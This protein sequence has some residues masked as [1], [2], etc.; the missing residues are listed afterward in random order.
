MYGYCRTSPHW[1]RAGGCGSSFGC[2]H[3]YSSEEFPEKDGV[4]LFSLRTVLVHTEEGIR[5]DLFA[6]SRTD[7][8]C[9]DICVTVETGGAPVV[10]TAADAAV[11][12]CPG[13]FTVCLGDLGA[14]DTV[15]VHTQITDA[16]LSDAL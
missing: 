1:H 9:R 10:L 3:R 13:G 12:A 11:T 5:F 16:Q 6:E 7:A 4:P 15:C 2:C 8:V 14:G